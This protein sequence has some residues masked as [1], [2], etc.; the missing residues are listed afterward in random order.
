MIDTLKLHGVEIS[1]HFGIGVY[2]KETKIPAGVVLTQHIHPYDHISFFQSGKAIVRIGEEKLVLEA[3]MWINVKAGV[4][5]SVEATTDVVWYCSHVSNETD[6]NKID[7]S[8]LTRN[9]E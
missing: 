2:S 1:H 3:P 5:H 9:H 7:Q 8:I 4:E 6:I